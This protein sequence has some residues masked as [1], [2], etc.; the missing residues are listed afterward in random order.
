MTKPAILKV[1]RVTAQDIAGYFSLD[2]P[3]YFLARDAERLGEIAG[4]ADAV[5]VI[6]LVNKLYQIA[7]RERIVEELAAQHGKSAARKYLEAS[8]TVGGGDYA[9]QLLGK[10]LMKVILREVM[11]EVRGESGVG[12]GKNTPTT[13]AKRAAK[14][15]TGG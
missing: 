9:V 7:L 1:R 8:G 4:A 13:A 15:R 3:G 10:D 11:N 2:S 6:V 12:S 14:R 5:E